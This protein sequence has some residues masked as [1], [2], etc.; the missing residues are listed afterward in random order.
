MWMIK[1]RR[2]HVAI[3]LLVTAAQT[4]SCNR[5]DGNDSKS[6]Q[7]VPLRRC[8]YKVM[9]DTPVELVTCTEYSSGFTETCAGLGQEVAA[10]PSGSFGKCTY[11]FTTYTATTYSYYWD[12]IK[13]LRIDPVINSGGFVNEEE[14]KKEGQ[15]MDLEGCKN[16]GGTYEAVSASQ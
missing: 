1:L 3:L 9:Q 4:G 16:A 2:V 13:K 10:C 8:M 14:L 5:D 11:N 6:T 7:S 12:L 15:T